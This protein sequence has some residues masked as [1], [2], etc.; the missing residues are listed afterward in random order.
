[1]A[2]LVRGVQL[3]EHHG[4]GRRLAQVPHP[5]L[6]GLKVRRVDHKLLPNTTLE[7]DCCQ[8]CGRTFR[9]VYMCADLGLGVIGRRGPHG[10][11]VAAVAQ[12]GQRKAAERLQVET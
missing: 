12:L 9:H 1:M 8:G 7:L 3:G 10:S 4:V 6:G 5:K 2:R 11:G